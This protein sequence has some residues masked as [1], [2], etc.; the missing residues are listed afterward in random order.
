MV[1]IFIQ[2]PATNASP[3]VSINIILF[4]NWILSLF[5][6]GNIKQET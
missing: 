5:A 3:K 6:V 4:L 1:R 2:H